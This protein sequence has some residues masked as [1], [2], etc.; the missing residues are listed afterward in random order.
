[1]KVLRRPADNLVLQVGINIDRVEHEG[2]QNVIRVET[3]NDLFYIATKDRD[4]YEIF[5]RDDIPNDY[6][7]SGY[8]LE[9]DVWTYIPK[10][11]LPDPDDLTENYVGS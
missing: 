9:N 8:Y 6:Y 4:T 11:V 10:P 1:M 5:D 7:P 3:S 2:E